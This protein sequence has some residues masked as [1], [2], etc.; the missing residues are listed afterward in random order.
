MR[1]GSPGSSGTSSVPDVFVYYS[2]TDLVAP[3]TVSSS[4]RRLRL[5][6]IS[7]PGGNMVDKVESVGDS[8]N[9]RRLRFIHIPKTGGSSIEHEGTPVGYKWGYYDN[10]LNC[11]QPKLP[12]NPWGQHCFVGADEC[13]LWHVPPSASKILHKV[14]HESPSFCVVRH[15]LARFISEYFY[16]EMP[17]NNATFRSKATE[18]LNNMQQSPY[19]LD[20][21]LVPQVDYVFSEGVQVCDHV[22]RFENMAAEF[23]ALMQE[24]SIDAAL[25]RHDRKAPSCNLEVPPEIRKTIEHVYNQDYKAFGYTDRM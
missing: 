21:H 24:Y 17:C 16:R 25:T 13:S 22:I 3:S 18:W 14:Y 19:S 10:D 2:D 6:P 8:N 12:L 15:P 7:K 1:S 11:E 9:S 20:C 5:L 4:S 23:D